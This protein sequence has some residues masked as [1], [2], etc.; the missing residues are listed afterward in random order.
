MKIKPILE[1]AK[2]IGIL[3]EEIELYGEYKSKVKL[4]IL[5]RLKN[6][7]K[8]KYIV[9]TGITPTPLGEGK[10]TTALGISAALNKF[11]KTSICCIRQPSLGPFFGIK[12]ASGG[13]GIDVVPKEDFNLF[14]NGDFYAISSAHNLCTSFLFNAIYRSQI[15]ISKDKTFW[16]YVY[17]FSDRF[18]REVTIGEDIKDNNFFPFRTGFDSTATSEVMS[19]VSLSC[20]FQELKEKLSRIVLGF[21][22]SNIPVTT[23]DIKVVGAMA[24]L[25]KDTLKPNLMQTTENTPVFVHTG[26]FANISHGNS[27]IVA[28]KI[29][30]LLSDYVITESG[31]G[32]DCGFE[33]FVN[34]KCRYSKENPDCALLVCTLRALKVHSGKIEVKVGKPLPEEVCRENIKLL[35]EGSVNLKKHIENIKIFGIPV[36]VV[37]NKFDTDTEKEINYVVKFAKEFGA[38]GVAVSEIW[39]K[40]VEGAKDVVDYVI[41]VCENLKSKFKFLYSLEEPIEEKIY[42]VA[43]KIYGA[44]DICI[45]QKASKK[46]EILKQNGFDKLPVCIAKTQFSLSHEPSLKG[47]PNDFV[48][49]IDDVIPF[50]GAGYITVI[51]GNIKT[52]PGLPSQPMGTKLDINENG[53]IL[54]F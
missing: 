29:A 21:T 51:C 18:L 43:T 35:E 14:L 53:N 31:F 26:P 24:L 22:E 6:N 42:K 48:L 25:L 41:K 33:K 45:S 17:E 19:I 37:I 39:H 47:A 50:V 2:S 49:P 5:D 27:S 38:D 3:K 54:Y 40:G 32:S 16:R 34:I 9:V 30:L 36:V 13:G 7:K 23:Q 44:K 20:S 46:L 12:G 8:A 10:T 4:E 15:K 52:L 28:D 1:I 11:G